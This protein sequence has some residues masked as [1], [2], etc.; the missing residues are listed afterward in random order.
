[1]KNGSRGRWARA[2]RWRSSGVSVGG[3]LTVSIN[4]PAVLCRICAISFGHGLIGGAGN[5]LLTSAREVINLAHKGRLRPIDEIEM[6][7]S[8]S[9]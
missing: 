2:A 5:C 1:M 4:R 9:T 3:I 6:E 8:H 7:Q